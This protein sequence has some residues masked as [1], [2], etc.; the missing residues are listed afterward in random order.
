MLL[1]LSLMTSILTSSL[2]QTNLLLG[3]VHLLLFGS[4][5]MLVFDR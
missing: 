5:L 2:L 4:Y 1:V 3:N